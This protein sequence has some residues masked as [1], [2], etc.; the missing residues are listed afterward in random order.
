MK[1]IRLKIKL[2][3]SI[4]II[5][6]YFLVG[7]SYS[8]TLSPMASAQSCLQTI[9][10]LMAFMRE[11]DRVAKTGMRTHNR[12]YAQ[13]LDEMTRYTSLC[14]RCKTDTPVSE[15]PMP[16]CH[17]HKLVHRIS[18]TVAIITRQIDDEEIYVL[19]T[20]L[21]NGNK[22]YEEFIVD[23]K[24]GFL[25]FNSQK[26]GVV[27]TGKKLLDHIIETRADASYKPKKRRSQDTKPDKLHT[28][29]VLMDAGNLGEVN[30]FLK[31]ME[32][33][34]LYLEAIAS[35]INNT[36]RSGNKVNF[37]KP[38]DG[39]EFLMVVHDVTKKEMVHLSRR[40]NRNVVES[41]QVQSVF[42]TQISD[43][44]AEMEHANTSILGQSDNDL[45]NAQKF[46]QTL[47]DTKRLLLTLEKDNKMAGNITIA[48]AR[49]RP[50]DTYSKLQARMSSQFGL[51]KACYLFWSGLL[52]EAKK[53]KYGVTDPIQTCA[54][55]KKHYAR[56]DMLLPPVFPPVM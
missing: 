55:F 49:I 20:L 36:P 40:L 15:C 4:Y 39:D 43:L 14:L 9:Q 54:K 32:A 8:G 28:F 31:Q 56:N 23:S 17:R 26:K 29:V 42:D 10:S 22:K 45:N 13:Q 53:L 27:G 3:F 38:S 21:P 50:G 52:T 24:S 41:D 47:A 34:D 44:L 48:A 33:G 11:V 30:Y 1:I 7:I 37:F 6:L 35:V 51:I 2:L 19:E 25:S 5:F 18:D 12:S 16:K 46:S